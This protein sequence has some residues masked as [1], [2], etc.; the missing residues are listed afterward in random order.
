[1]RGEDAALSVTMLPLA[2]AP[3]RA[4]GGRHQRRHA[5]ALQRSTPTCVGRT[6]APPAPPATVPEHPH[7]RGEDTSVAMSVQMTSGAPPR[8]WG[9]RQPQRGGEVVARSTPTCV[10][11]TGVAGSRCLIGPEHPHVRGEDFRWPVSTGTNSGAPP[12]AWGGHAPTHRCGPGCRSTPTCV[13][14]TRYSA[15]RFARAAEHPHVRG[16]DRSPADRGMRRGGAPPRAWGG[17]RTRPARRWTARSTPTCVGRTR[18]GRPTAG[19]TT[20]HPHVRGE[21]ERMASAAAR[22]SG[23][24]PRA[25]GG[26]IARRTVPTDVRST[27]TCVGR[28]S[29]RCRACRPWPEH[30]HVRGE[31]EECTVTGDTANGAPPRAWGGRGQAQAAADRHRSTPTC[32]GRTARSPPAPVATTEH[33]HV[34]GE[35]VTASPVSRSPAGAPPRAWGGLGSTPPEIPPVRST[36][37][38]VGRTN[39][40]SRSRSRSREHPHVRGEDGGAGGNLWGGHGAPPRAWGGQV[41]GEQSVRDLRSTPTCVGRT[42][43]ARS[44]SA[45]PSEHPHVR[46]EDSRERTTRHGCPGAPPRA[47]G[48]HDRLGHHRAAARS[49]PTCVG[50]T[51]TATATA[52]SWTEHPHVRGEDTSPPAVLSAR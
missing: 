15:A 2:G 39:S 52:N 11:R 12:R 36:P 7:V 40:R 17:R 42:P 8:A 51:S 34:R 45:D 14:R 44:P 37:T 46:G 21:D 31:D 22:R 49:T 6:A 24:P 28:T 10:G 30:P 19:T 23:A 3:P 25:W 32:V 33:P 41:S 26:P 13:G 18:S 48:G 50:R 47:W 27:P 43:A 29:R 1:M 5:P 9:G 20:E 4:W 35:D 16:E 38:C